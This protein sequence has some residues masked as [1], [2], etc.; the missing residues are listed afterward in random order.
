M[1]LFVTPNW[2]GWLETL[3]TEDTRAAHLN[4]GFSHA[5]WPRSIEYFCAARSFTTPVPVRPNDTQTTIAYQEGKT[6]YE[7]AN[8]KSL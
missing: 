4:A 7:A 3:F 1:I 2:K 6:C 8:G 5:L